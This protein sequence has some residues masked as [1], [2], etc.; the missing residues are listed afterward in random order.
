MDENRSLPVRRIAE[1][2]SRESPVTIDYAPRQVTIYRLFEMELDRL[3]TIQNSL[4][5]AFFG[6]AFGA[7]LAVTITL[8]TVDITSPRTYGAYWGTFW[9]TA[10]ASVYFFVRAIMDWRE[11]KHYVQRIKEQRGGQAALSD[12]SD[13]YSRLDDESSL[14]KVSR[15]K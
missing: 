8:S 15:N 7:W 3:G 4:H 6:I 2:E 13:L 9:I 12:V 1:P 5:L 14:S 11:A 10:L